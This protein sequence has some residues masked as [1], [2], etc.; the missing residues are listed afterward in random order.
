MLSDVSYSWTLT[1]TVFCIIFGS[2]QVDSANAP[3]LEVKVEDE[4]AA[5][6]G[7]CD[8]YSE[9]SGTLDCSF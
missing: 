4:V 7:T 1:V 5:A 6:K 8:L 2:M 9:Q 3:D